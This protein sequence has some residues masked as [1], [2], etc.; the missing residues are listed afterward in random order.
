MKKIPFPIY[1]VTA[2]LLL[3]AGMTASC[4]KL[5]EIPG[6][7]PTEILQSEQFADSATAMTAVAAV[8]SYAAGTGAGFGYADGLLTECT[9]LSADELISTVSTNTNV[10]GFYNYG[11]TRTN[12]GITQLWNNPYTQLYPVNAILSGVMASASLS[13]SLKT[14]ITGEMK[15]VRALYYF[16]LVNLFGGLPLVTSTDYTATANIPRSSADSIYS[17]I[18]ADLTEAQQ[19]LTPAYPSTG[20]VRPN[21]YTASAFLAKVYLFRQQWQ[22]AYNAANLVISSGLYSLVFNPDSVFLNGSNEAIWQLP[23]TGPYEVTA[24]AYAFVPSV[25]GTVPKFELTPFLLNAF[26]PGD[27]RLKAWTGQSVVTTGTAKDT[28]YYPY[29]Y[30]NI[31][32]SSPTTEDY[33]LFRLGD[34][35]LIRA[36]ASAY[37]GDNAGA[38][39]DLNLVRAR[40]GL[41]ASA[42]D[43]SSQ[44][45]VLSA[46]MHERQVELFCEWGNRWYDLNRTGTA[47]SVLGAEKTGW[48][49]NAALYPLP[50]AQIQAD[51]QLVQNPGY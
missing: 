46:I 45:A 7:P 42:A 27:L 21:L 51:A 32:T 22:N 41:P 25:S 34:L 50:Q 28:L 49:A 1:K 2:G 9:G 29:K 33:M 40:A 35:Y 30:K 24:E 12:S 48:Q 11:L 44:T 5:I 39:A 43:P 37:L 26:E 13:A 20:R 4:K 23:A 36:E 18:I 3:M 15:V 47:A 6:N 10:T 14:Q 38:L 8:Y 31:L 16:N 17:Q 19:T